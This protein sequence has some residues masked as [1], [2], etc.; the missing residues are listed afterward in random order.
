MLDRVT[1][2]LLDPPEEQLTTTHFAIDFY[3]DIEVDVWAPAFYLGKALHALQDSFTHTVRSNNLSKIRHVMNF[4][5]A[6]TSAYDESQDGLRHSSSMDACGFEP[7]E[8]IQLKLPDT[9]ATNQCSERA[10]VS[11]SDA[12]A[13]RQIVRAALNAS[14]DLLTAASVELSGFDQGQRELF[15]TNWMELEQ[16]SEL[17]CDAC[18]RDNQF[19][20][21]PYLTLVDAEPTGP[22]LEH[23][24]GCSAARRIPGSNSGP[25]V[26]SLCSLLLFSRVRRIR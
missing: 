22:Y 19:C 10:T 9:E 15:L 3:G 12:E 21:S 26:L 23:A 14:I 4:V 2:A 1:L 17:N 11:L 16:P 18:G 7:S 8:V 13:T 6:I 24:L 25:W 5:E 20:G